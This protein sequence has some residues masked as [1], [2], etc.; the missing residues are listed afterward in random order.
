MK[1]F[2]KNNKIEYALLYL[3]IAQASM[4]F[5]MG[6][7]YLFFGSAAAILIYLKN[8]GFTI[9]H[10]FMKIF[11][12]FFILFSVQIF[13]LD[14]FNTNVFLGYLLRLLWAYSVIRIIGPNF[15]KYFI[16]IL[17]YLTIL[18]LV[19]Y[20]LNLLFS[21]LYL[22]E[23]YIY[24]NFVKPLEIAG[25]N[26]RSNLIFYTSD[27]WLL[28]EYPRNAGPFW[29]PGGY[30]V[31]LVL[32]FAFNT[33]ISKNIT[34]RINL[35][36]GIAIITTFSVASYAAL[37]TFVLFYYLYVDPNKAVAFPL[38]FVLIIMAV[39]SYGEYDFL[40]SKLSKKY[41]DYQRISQGIES[42]EDA[43]QTLDRFSATQFDLIAF[44]ESPI[45]GKSKFQSYEFQRNT[46]SLTSF[47]REFGLIGIIF[48]MFF[49]HKSFS[50]FV[51]AYGSK[52][53][54]VN[55]LILTYIVT[56]LS[57]GIFGKPFFMSMI[58]LNF[59]YRKK[60]ESNSERNTPDA[61]T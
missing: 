28:Y 38:V 15:L 25:I 31:F 1:K 12:F 50:R 22:I 33:V 13:F 16:N 55:I 39:I 24:L 45:I 18:G 36:F 47:L 29:E 30:G 8:F 9:D 26:F 59:A 35:V 42:Y 54:F 3:L 6:D 32:G 58:L 44:S 49:M 40:G 2:Q 41:R 52:R 10:E 37:L 51:L 4:P 56:S 48:Y 19:I 7:F 20:S 61:A 53:V 60:P 23:Q 57:Q 17:L 11:Y 34:N 14:E 5:F 27:Y 43:S 46:N 21:D